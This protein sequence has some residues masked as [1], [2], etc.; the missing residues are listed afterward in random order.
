MRTTPL[1]LPLILAMATAGA[2]QIPTA[3]N[4][5][6]GYSYSRSEVFSG[7]P[8]APALGFLQPPSRSSNF[9]GWEASA[10]GKFLPFL[11]V[12][13]DVSQR[14]ASQSFT[15]VCLLPPGNPACGPATQTVNSRVFTGMIGP[16]V[17]VPIGRFTPF[18]HA[19]FGGAH[20]SDTKAASNSDTSFSTAIGGG[21]DYKL[22]KGVAWRFQGD[23][24]H[25]RF[26]GAGQ[27]NL[28]LSTGLVLRF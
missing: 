25:T 4:V 18:A 7:R 13:I 17:S 9:N 24:L 12:E 15:A 22:V 1:T 3:G 10:E 6:F 27:N 20:I 11:G 14:Y 28:R 5:F 8:A 23:A 26:F 21:I 16:R 19:L 2:A